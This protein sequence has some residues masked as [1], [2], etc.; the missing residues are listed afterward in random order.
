MNGMRVHFVREVRGEY[1]GLFARFLDRE[2]K[3]QFA[4]LYIHRHP[5]IPNEPTDVVGDRLTL[6]QL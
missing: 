1:K 4:A 6:R 3:F 5:T 2:R